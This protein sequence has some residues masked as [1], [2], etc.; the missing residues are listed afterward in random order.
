MRIVYITSVLGPKGGSE[1]YTRDLIKEL[2]DS[3]HTIL[4]ITTEKHEFAHKNIS[5]IHLPVF[6]HHALHKFEAPL[7][8]SS[9]MKAAKNFKPDIVQSHSN[10]L[11]GYLGHKIKNELKIPHIILIE[12]LSSYN[13]SLHAKIIHR[14]EKFMLPKLK[15]DKLLLWTDRM[16]NNF[17]IPWGIDAS[18]IVVLHPALKSENYNSNLKAPWIREKYGPKLIV[19]MKTLWSTNVIGLTYIVRAMVKVSKKHPEWKYVIFGGGKDKQQLIDLVKELGLENN[20]LFGGHIMSTKAKDV[21]AETDIAPHSFVYE[22]STSISL[23]E[24]L[25]MGK[26]CVV[27]D[28]GAVKEIVQDSVLVV[29]PENPDAI[30]DAIIKLIET[31]ALRKELGRRARK[32]FEENYT[33]HESVNCIE[34]IYSK[35]LK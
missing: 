19:S 15:Y 7:F 24:Y 33:I 21:L 18:K 27:T 17:A 8:A 31:P 26:A 10:S 6:G 13:Q 4:V 22:F 2:A 3:G 9:V 11:M 29:P 16:K 23:L 12:L 32:L 30:A 1:I 14:I 34:T 20:V 5:F 25:A 35:L 28:V